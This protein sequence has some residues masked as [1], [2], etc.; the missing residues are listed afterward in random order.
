MKAHRLAVLLS[1]ALALPAVVAQVPETG[2]DLSQASAG[3]A[4]EEGLWAAW[5]GELQIAWNRHLLADLGLELSPAKGLLDA[6]QDGV[7]RLALRET[8]GLQFKVKGRAFDGF[9][10][11]AVSVRGGYELTAAGRVIPLRDFSLRPR[12]GN[13]YVLELVSGDGKAWFFVDR[14]MY[15]LESDAPVLAL[16]AMDLRIT[17][18][19]AALIGKP[20]AEG[21]TVAGLTMLVDIFRGGFPAYSKNCPSSSR[22][23]GMEVPGGGGAV[24]EADVFMKN[25]HFSY[26]RRTADADGPGGSD[27]Q[28]VFTPS[29]TL[30]NNRNN[31]SR[32]E[33][34]IGDPLGTSAGTHAADVVWR[35]KFSA[36][37]PPYD[38]DQHPYLIWNLY[39][40][41][42][43][44]RIEQVG[45]SGVKHAFLTINTSCDANPGSG[46]ILGRGCEDVYAEGNNDSN[47]ALGPR[48]EI[49]PATG[50][51][52]RC[53]SIYDPGCTGSQSS[54]GN[55]S[56]SQRMLVRE[57]HI[58]PLANPGA[59]W[60]FESWYVVRD[61]IDIYN[62]MQTRP[63]SFN[64]TG[65]LWSVANG[66][67]LRL[68][69]AIDRWVDPQTTDPLQRNEELALPGGRSKVAVRV[70]DL[71]DGRHR[72]DYAVM[73][74]EFGVAVTDGREPN[75]RVISN[76][77][78]V[79]FRVPRGTAMQVEGL[80]FADGDNDP[81]NDWIASIEPDA[82]VW[83]APPGA[84]LN[85]GTLFRFSLIA[86][87]APESGELQLEV[88]DA[89]PPSRAA[90]ASLRP[91][92]EPLPRH[93]V[94][95]ELAGLLPGRSLGL[96]LNGGSP[97]VLEVDG[98]FAFPEPVVDGGSYAVGIAQLPEGQRCE[99]SQG[100]GTIEGSDIDDVLVLCEEI[101]LFG[102]GG[103]L[104]GLEAGE[105]RLSLNA[106]E[107]LAL[108]SNGPFAFV[109]RLAEGEAYSVAVVSQPEGHACL[110]SEGTGLVGT[111][112]IDSVAVNCERTDQP[113]LAVDDSYA[114]VEDGSLV[115]AAPGVLGNDE[116]RV[117]ALQAELL[118]APLHGSLLP[119]LAADGGFSYQPAPDFCGKD[120]FRYRASA[121]GEQD[122]ATVHLVVACVDD[123]PRTVGTPAD[124]WLAL[125][126]VVDL[127]MAV[128]FHEPDGQALAY[129]ATA[130]P[131][132]LQIDPASGRIGGVLLD[133]LAGSPYRVLI[134]ASDGTHPTVAR[135]RFTIHLAQPLPAVFESGF[136]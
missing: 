6:P 90:V 127:D 122:E 84:A 25:F 61:D 94:G 51:W 52:G 59:S 56:F 29:S 44:G 102:I 57:S 136:E 28:V 54:P 16:H 48:R 104:M 109:T 120:S 64:W 58:D 53:G 20:Y 15:A 74:F 99:L 55:T 37:C 66:T 114:L 78:F 43:L 108:G 10:G 129:S 18:E 125:G 67:P 103:S 7:E 113:L 134:S 82:V 60:L 39:R 116:S 30:K 5:G 68:G 8:V 124:L 96:Q 87:A 80:E 47:T 93:F 27:G 70:A 11:G 133:G 3:T 65:S 62:T 119:A 17:P 33:T 45:R 100:S 13:P 101:P 46:Y 21:L 2:I 35:T 98:A 97:L 12:E 95:G 135:Q 1:A 89:E 40:I 121:S 50:Q 73:N 79:G 86:D 88:P 131:P 75:L 81:S 83:T 85:W 132:G 123:A 14:L 22:W 126:A 69:P 106:A 42:A 118:D 24:Y 107:E 26:T 38:N 71:G 76:E 128:F 72:Y 9:Q 63:G 112:D 110:V 32:M 31:G 77:G 34:I 36:N 4:G 23:P 49:I 41:D 117:G 111:A 19:F 130:L 91:A 115:I 92:G 105:L